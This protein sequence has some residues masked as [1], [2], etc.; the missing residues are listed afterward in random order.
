MNKII[1]KEKFIA[2]RKAIKHLANLDRDRASHKNGVGFSRKHTK[3]G[4]ELARKEYWD[5]NDVK[6]AFNLAYYYR[7]QIPQ[8][9][10]QIIFSKEKRKNK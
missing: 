3:I 1:P 4:H 2:L 9:L 7:R 10:K 6:V 8:Y 5:K